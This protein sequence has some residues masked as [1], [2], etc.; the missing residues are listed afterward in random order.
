MKLKQCSFLGLHS[1]EVLGPPS[2]FSVNA[3][4]QQYHKTGAT[5]EYNSRAPESCMVPH[6]PF[7]SICPGSSSTNKCL[8]L[9]QF[10]LQPALLLQLICVPRSLS[11]S[12]DDSTTA[13]TLGNGQVRYPKCMS[14][15][16]QYILHE[17]SPCLEMG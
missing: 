7:T 6:F 12:R 3:Q 13:F 14:E 17:F 1:A 5:T 8:G 16:T 2:W 11:K 4:Y 9:L 15:E 10:P